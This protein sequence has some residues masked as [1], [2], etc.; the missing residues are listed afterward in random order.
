MS[1][2]MLTQPIHVAA[3]LSAVVAFVFMLAQ[4]KPLK[5]VFN[6]VPPLAWMY[7]L[8]MLATT[9]GILPNES[10]FYSPFM[11]RY[12]L[13]AVLILLLV[14]TDL[15]AITRL[16]WRA[17][18]MMGF[19]TV[20][21]VVGAIVSFAIFGKLF[22]G[23]L[24][25]ES[26]KGIA[27]L[28]GS[29]IG[30]SA[31]LTAVKESLN[32][33]NDLLAPLIIVDTVVAYTWLG[34]LI[35]LVPYQDR[36]DRWNRVDTSTIDQVA[37]K[38]EQDHEAHARCPRTADVAWMLGLAMA[39]SQLCMVGGGW[40]DSL[41]KSSPLSG[42]INGYGWGILLVTVAGLVLAMTPA[43]RLDHAGSSS[44]GYAGL[45]LL[46]TTY[47]AQADLRS[48]LG[49]PVYLGIGVTWVAIHAVFLLIGM[50]VMRAPMV[51]AASASMANIGGPASAPVV[52]AAYR[53][54]LAPVGLLLAIIGG[55][56]GT[57]IALFVVA[58][59]CSSVSG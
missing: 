54:S 25:D 20:G 11:T 4:L 17:V 45:Y 59:A 42:L 46:L 14:Q 32:L 35:A 2:P 23:Q 6:F 8:P 21:I 10:P 19:A 39:G 5:P 18:G 9:A 50:R 37:V 57:P 58:A 3:F 12:I 52:A 55:I 36:I 1:E 51:L 41:F 34:L 7:F 53:Q 44:I 24:S 28:S 30:G 48:V 16:G 49:V 33:S 29:W 43:R 40:V 13:P 38:L 27:A 22:G 15:M 31:N 47:G 26:W 56:I